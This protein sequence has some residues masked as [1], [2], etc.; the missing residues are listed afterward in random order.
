[1]LVLISTKRA[2]YRDGIGCLKCGWDPKALKRLGQGGQRQAYFISQRH[3]EY[4]LFHE[5]W[6]STLRAY[7]TI[8]VYHRH[9]D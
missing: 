7:Q 8:P 4:H 9:I 1:M 2:I 5:V 3:L 6:Q